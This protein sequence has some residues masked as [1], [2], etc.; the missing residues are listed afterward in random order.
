MRLD[1]CLRFLRATCQNVVI[2]CLSLFRLP[3][4]CPLL[5]HPLRRVHRAAAW[6]F[7][8]DP[9]VRN[10]RHHLRPFRRAASL[11][12]RRHWS[13]AG[14]HLGVLQHVCAVRCRVSTRPRVAGLVDCLL[15]HH[16]GPV[17]LQRPHE[18]RDSLHGGDL[19]RAHRPPLHLRGAPL[20]H[21]DVHRGRPCPRERVPRHHHLLL[22]VQLCHV[23]PRREERPALQPHP[24][25]HLRKLWRHLL[26]P[27][28]LYHRLPVQGRW[29]NG[30]DA[31]GAS[32][33]P[34]HLDQ[35]QDWQGA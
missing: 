34:P 7:R 24:P 35:P 29:D 11:H 12:S 26:D 20:R 14:V 23:L 22:H 9:R 2:Y 13:R 28:L 16:S 1:G 31:G 33:P 27:H 30:S 10:L 25:R 21:K 6:R 3:L 5:W 8:N 4:R 32:D 17:R 15:H 18:P 19:Q